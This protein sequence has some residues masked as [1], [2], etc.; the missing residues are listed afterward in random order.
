M[1]SHLPIYISN[2]E[3]CHFSFTF[4]GDQASELFLVEK[5][6]VGLGAWFVS[7]APHRSPV[8]SE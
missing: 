6:E 1:H 8:L 7:E 4:L 5:E 3:R 2:A